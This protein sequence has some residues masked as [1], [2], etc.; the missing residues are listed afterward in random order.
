MTRARIATV[1][2]LLLAMVLPVPA[3]AQGSAG[4]AGRFP[5]TV[6]VEERNEGPLKLLGAGVG[7]ALMDRYAAEFGGLGGMLEDDL[8]SVGGIE[9]CVFPN[10]VP[11]DAQALGWHPYQRLHAAAFGSEGVVVVSAYLITPSIDA[12]RNGIMH[13]W[14]WRLGDGL[15]PQALAEDVKGLYR[16]RLDSTVQNVHNAL[17]RQNIGLAEP[18][19]PFNWMA[20]AM[21]DPLLFDPE[22]SYGGM[23]DFAGFVMDSGAGAVLMDPEPV[24]VADLDEQWRQALYDESGSTLGGSKEWILGAVMIFGLL[25]LAAAMA[26]LTRRARLRAHQQRRAAALRMLSGQAAVGRSGSP[27]GGR[28]DAGVGSGPP[29]TVG[30][31]GDD[32]DRP[33][34]RSQAGPGFDG[35]PSGSQP[36]D[37]LFRHPDFAGED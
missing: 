5:D 11:W 23:G 34:T 29:G 30:R 37:D 7:D 18:W 10:A 13:V 14:L 8:G 31:H 16:N 35:V 26:Y 21:T 4:C 33:P 15:Y 24:E 17:V 12:G 6:F 9:V 28:P 19:P 32:R 1:V 25:A 27:G 3:G 22:K 2:L 20:G 36:G